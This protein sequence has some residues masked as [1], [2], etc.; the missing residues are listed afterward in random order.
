M[1]DDKALPFCVHFWRFREDRK[2]TF[3]A[4]HLLTCFIGCKAQS[5]GGNGTGCYVP[6]LGSDLRGDDQQLTCADQG[7]DGIDG[8]LMQRMAGLD[9]AQ[10]NVCIDEDH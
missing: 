4:S 7:G 6:E 2:E 5:V 10:P 3:E 9:A 8:R 1:G